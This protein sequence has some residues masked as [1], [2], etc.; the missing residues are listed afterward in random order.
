[1]TDS[2]SIDPK[3]LRAGPIRHESLAPD[4]LEQIRAVYD[5]IGPY[6]SDSLEQFE[7]SFMR[8][9]NPASEVAAWCNI[10]MAWLTFHER[11]FGNQL[12]IDEQEKQLIAALVSIS[13]GVTDLAAL[14]VPPEFGR[15]LLDCYN[16]LEEE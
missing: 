9:A 3:K 8:D 1:M 7:I 6:I 12:L 2:E 14:G 16:H 11:Q 13:T 4:I 5:V 10:T 15:E